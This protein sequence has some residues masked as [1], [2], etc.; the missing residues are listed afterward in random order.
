MGIKTHDFVV[1]N[2]ISSILEENSVCIKLVIGQYFK[3]L[4]T[5]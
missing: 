2:K 5:F 3:H 1:R 4:F